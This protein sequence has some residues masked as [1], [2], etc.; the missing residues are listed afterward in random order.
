MAKY[1]I[2]IDVGGTFTHAVAINN[3]TYELVGQT[4]V[5]TTHTAAEGVAKGIV[6]SLRKLISDLSINPDD[7]SFIAHSTTQ[8]TN[9]LLE[10]DVACVGVIGTGSGLEGRRSKKE[11][12]LGHIELGENKKIKVNYRY[13]D[14][15]DLVPEKINEALESLLRDGSEVIVAAEAFSVDD[16]TNEQKILD[17]ALKKDIPAVGTHE[18]S[19]LYGLRMRTRTAVINASILPKMMNTALATEKCVKETGIKAPLMIMRSDGGVMSID[20]MKKRPI[21]TILSGPAAG[22]ASALLYVKISDGIFLEVGGTSTDIAVIRNGKAVVKSAEIGGHKL[23]LRTLDSR[24]VGVAGGSMP[25]ISGSKIIDVGPRSAHIAGLTYS[26]FAD[27]S[28]DPGKIAVTTTCAANVLELV[29]PQDWAY[30]NKISAEAA[31]RTI[32]DPEKISKEILKIASSKIIKTINSLIKDYKIEKQ[33][34]VLIG[35]GGGAA[36]IVPFTASEMGLSFKIAENHA[37][38]SAIGAA[39]AMVTDTIERSCV[40]PKEKDIIK[41]R[42]DAESSVVG[43][44]AF[45]GTVEVTVEI[46]R[47]KNVLRAIACGATELRKK[48]LFVRESSETEK[49]SIAADS[50]GVEAGS[51]ELYYN[52]PHFGVWRAQCKKTSFFGLVCSTKYPVRV[53][54]R[55]GIIRLSKD[56]AAVS[57]TQ[58]E[59]AGETLK[60]LLEKYTVYGDAGSKLPQVY[61]LAGPRIID[62]SG[63]M[64]Q[65][66]VLSLLSI[67]TA[68]LHKQ[69][70]IVLIL[71]L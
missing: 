42:K 28:T 9:A 46:D 70:K 25:R 53:V 34:A 2:G 5:P 57:E 29:R 52:G 26:C 45:P 22:I 47:Q 13:L 4:K 39:L 43:M 69:E 62:M 37:V 33:Q 16:P 60:G 51:V 58:A 41:I 64:R 20:Q 63:M 11:T 71:G 35:G 54:D 50:M 17:L 56:N 40:D 8:A 59:N 49:R 18:I 24:T 48:D 19:G 10:G 55:E 3:D 65:E 12:D 36:A 27:G 21:L 15:F 6:D 68:V 61:A 30:G 1:R 67:E 66:Q 32:G 23:F 7:V 31:L 38:I 44:G 14:S